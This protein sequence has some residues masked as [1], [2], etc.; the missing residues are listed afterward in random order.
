MESKGRITIEDV[1]AYQQKHGPRMTEQCLRK[2][3]VL[4]Q[5]YNAYNLPLGKEL[6]E[7][8]NSEMLKLSSKILLD[9]NANFEDKA[10]FGAYLTIAQNWAKKIES[11]ESTVR[12]ITEA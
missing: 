7:E 2:L 5:F 1:K 11:Y 8:I 3:G 12:S 6:L 4:Q 9:P 10:K